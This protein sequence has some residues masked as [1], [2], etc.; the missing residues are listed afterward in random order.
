MGEWRQVN[1]IFPVWDQAEA[2]ALAHLVPELARA[3]TGGLINKWF[4]MRKHPAWRI[5]YFLNNGDRTAQA[6]IGQHLDDLAASGQITGWTGSIYEPEAHA[7][8]GD[9]AMDTA[10]RFFHGDT[11][12]CL[13]YLATQNGAKAD[14]RRELSLLLC[15]RML[16]AAGLDWYEQGDVWTRVASTG[17]A[18]AR[19]FASSRRPP[20]GRPPPH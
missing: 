11:N 18:C 1:V 4:F 13:A 10:H 20:Y 5:R 3:E 16:R 9:E 6:G 12:G 2:F 17:T 19:T 14:H 8:G 7:F 15:T